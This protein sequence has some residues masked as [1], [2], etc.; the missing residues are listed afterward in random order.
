MASSPK[1]IAWPRSTSTAT[2]F[3]L[4]ATQLTVLP[5]ADG[6]ASTCRSQD[7]ER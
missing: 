7:D 1:E 3:S 5:Y 6:S 4:R 2:P